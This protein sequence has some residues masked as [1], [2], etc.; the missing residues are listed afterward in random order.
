MYD[1]ER[2]QQLERKREEGMEQL[3]MITAI[4]LLPRFGKW[5]GPA[6]VSLE[7]RLH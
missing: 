6:C 5:L 3:K 7:T 2:E 4:I 1:P